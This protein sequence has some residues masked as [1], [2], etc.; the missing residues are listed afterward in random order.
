L[1]EHFHQQ[2]FPDGDQTPPLLMLQQNSFQ[3]LQIRLPPSFFVD[4]HYL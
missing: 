1:S 4:L 3:A 2:I